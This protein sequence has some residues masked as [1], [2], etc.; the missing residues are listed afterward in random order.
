MFPDSES[1]FVGLVVDSCSLALL[2][3][4]VL[5]VRERERERQS[6]GRRRVTSGAGKARGGKIMMMHSFSYTFVP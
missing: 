1:D 6:S 3:I 4:V 2:L 5:L